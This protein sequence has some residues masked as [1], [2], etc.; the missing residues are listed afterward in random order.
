MMLIGVD[1]AQH[2]LDPLTTNDLVVCAERSDTVLNQ[3]TNNTIIGCQDPTTSPAAATD[4]VVPA[5]S[6]A[7][8]H[9]PK[10]KP[11]LF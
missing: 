7:K 8:P 11:R 10:V 2:Y 1:Y 3:G 5:V 6:A 4:S 9:L